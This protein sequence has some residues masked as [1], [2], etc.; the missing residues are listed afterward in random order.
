[1]VGMFRCAAA[2]NQ[3][4]GLWEVSRVTDISFMFEGASAFN[5]N[6]YMWDV[7]K[8]LMCHQCFMMQLPSI[9]ASIAGMFQM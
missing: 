5:Q 4:I 6:I 9:K 8:L 2:F 7:S 1:M 3:N